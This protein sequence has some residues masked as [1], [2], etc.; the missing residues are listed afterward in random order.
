MQTFK[1]A[2][3][4]DDVLFVEEVNT[5]GALPVCRGHTGLHPVDE[6]LS[7]ADVPTRGTS[8]PS[9]ELVDILVREAADCGPPAPL[10]QMATS[11][12]FSATARDDDAALR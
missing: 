10:A 5:G 3:A 4:R 8:P 1:S 9:T 12:V 11:D 7:V 6:T 2:Y